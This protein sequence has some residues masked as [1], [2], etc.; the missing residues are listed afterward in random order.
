MKTYKHIF[1]LLAV[2]ML[3]LP[4]RQVQANDTVT[5]EYKLK[6]AFIYKILQFVQLPAKEGVDEPPRKQQIVIG[7]TD[8]AHI[9]D[10]QDTVE[11][12]QISYGKGKTY[13]IVVKDMTS[14]QLQK[15]D[16][17]AEL[18]ALY[19]C[20]GM[21]NG[22]VPQLLRAALENKVMAFGDT[23]G[24]LETGGTINFV[25]KKNK[26]RF[27][28]N[29]GTAEQAGIK[30]RSQLMKLAVKVIDKKMKLD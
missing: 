17:M 15:A 4:L 6:A 2:S 5:G 30:I 19:V 14:A 21:P 22:D 10:V 9:K 12:K 11:G 24:F 16:S 18:N 13:T 26:L 27:E 8:K 23:A 1:L 28:I 25:V 7:V 29:T 3:V 20:G